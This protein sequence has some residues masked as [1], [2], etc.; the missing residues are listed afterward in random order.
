MMVDIVEYEAPSIDVTTVEI[1]R[2][3]QA[4][5]GDYGE[6]GDGFDIEDNGDF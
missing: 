2:G 5:Y 1:E 6:A 4:S 3:Y